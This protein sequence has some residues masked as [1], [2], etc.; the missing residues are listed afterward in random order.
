MYKLPVN[1]FCYFIKDLVKRE[2][3]RNIL[4]NKIK[5]PVEY[6]K[7]NYSRNIDIN[8]MN[9]AI[10]IV[11]NGV[12]RSINENEQIEGLEI[13]INGNNNVVKIEFPF[14]ANNSRIEIIEND[15]AYVELGKSEAFHN[16]YIRVNWGGKQ[17][18]IMKKNCII[19]G[20]EFK[21]DCHGAIKIGEDCLFSNDIHVWADDGH[22]ILDTNTGEVLNEPK[23]AITIG[24][25]VWIAQGVRITKNARIHDN[26][27]IGG[28]AVAY[29]D[30]EESNVVIAGNPGKI[31]RRNITWDRRNTY[32]LQR[33]R[34]IFSLC[35]KNLK[36]MH[37][38][39][40]I[41]FIVCYK[42]NYNLQIKYTQLPSGSIFFII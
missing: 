12:E 30:Y 1:I 19:W 8:G 34:V 16:T 9:N 40:A 32:F 11:E 26:S 20:A 38:L 21:I 13:V 29:K 4:M 5:I 31:V 35:K 41:L 10:I 17:K 22:S 14:K 28:G 39:L 24:N 15:N 42:H 18:F 27:I 3:V 33:E 2:Y 36:N 37:Y 7:P 6:L 25:H 23:G